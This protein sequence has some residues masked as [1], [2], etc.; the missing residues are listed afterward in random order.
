MDGLRNSIGRLRRDT[1]GGVA[2]MAALCLLA[3]VG[4]VSLAIDMGHLY[5]TRN[6]L[7]NVAD[8]AALA[9]AGNLM[10]DYGAGAVRDAIAA[11][12]AALT[13]AQ[14]QSQLSGQTAVA[15]A[16]RNDLSL[17]FGA[18]D[19]Y[20]GNPATA[21]T[22]IGSTCSSDSNANAVK[23]TIIRASGTVYG[24]V[25]NFFG[26]IL[27]INTSQVSA[28]AI[29]YLG[30]VNE[31]PT[32]GVQVPL[33]L[34]STGTYS[35]LASNGRT[36]WLAR[37]F[38]PGEAVAS[39]P[40]TITFRD[41]GG[42]TVSVNSSKK[43]PTS[44]V[45]ALDPNQGYFYTPAANPSHN[46]VPDTI[47]NTIAKIYTPSLTGTSSVPVFVGDIKVGAQI[48]PAS[49][50]PWGSS[51]MKPMFDNLKTAYNAKKDASGKWR[52]TLAVHGPLSTSSLLQKTGF[53]SLARLLAPFW[54]S[55]AFACA[56]I[57]PPTTFVKTFVN[58]DI[59]AVT[60]GTGDDGNYTYPKKITTP[61]PASGT[62]TYSDQKDFLNRYPN[63]TWNLNT[64]TIQTVTG[65]STVSPPG[66][67]SG[68]PSNQ[69]INPSAPGNTGALASIPVLV[70]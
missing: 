23:I 56:T 49:E 65:A 42:S 27:G 64:V 11:Q 52:T 26:G 66:S 43:I 22:E 1:D 30:Y 32:G 5:T 55:E 69:V 37:L 18:W 2:V 21:W 61:A 6:E 31:V 16:D 44:P 46:T 20:K 13:V 40:K 17:I 57:Q 12:Q 47:K 39:A 51:N 15:D 48:Y 14:R 63:S 9:A 8:A 41:T 54:S 3:F 4:I 68:G 19:I 10:H 29:A 25:S 35:P 24:P 62:T 67:Q 34:P 28:T 70:R 50:Y 38:G 53:M 45:A 58:V 59:T 7:Q 33:A 36:G 60:S